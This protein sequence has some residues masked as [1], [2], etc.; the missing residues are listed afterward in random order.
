MVGVESGNVK[1]KASIKA[2]CEATNTEEVSSFPKLSALMAKNVNIQNLWLNSKDECVYLDRK[3]LSYI[4]K[5]WKLFFYTFILNYSIWLT[6]KEKEVHRC[7]VGTNS[8]GGGD[9]HSDAIQESPHNTDCIKAQRAS[10]EAADFW[11]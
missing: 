1:K 10:S 5:L 3:Y 8:Q 11:E 9:I 6:E 7:P 4:K 2:G